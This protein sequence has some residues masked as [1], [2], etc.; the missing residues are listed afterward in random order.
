MTN[1]L[2]FIEMVIDLKWWLATSVKH[3]HIINSHLQFGVLRAENN[4]RV[5]IF[6]VIEEENENNFWPGNKSSYSRHLSDALKREIQE[7]KKCTK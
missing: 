5:N 2:M 1:K 3:C 4:F 6:D 7:E